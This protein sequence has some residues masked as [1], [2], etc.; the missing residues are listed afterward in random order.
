MISN[1]AAHQSIPLASRALGYYRE[2]VHQQAA[3]VSKHQI[4]VYV[5][6]L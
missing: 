1:K 6:A 3:D 4:F 2:I 5:H